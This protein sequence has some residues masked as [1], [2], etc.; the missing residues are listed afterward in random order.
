VLPPKLLRFCA[1]VQLGR[2]TAL[3]ERVFLGIKAVLDIASLG[4]IEDEARAWF[5]YQ[6]TG[7]ECDFHLGIVKID[8]EVVWG[9]GSLALLKDSRIDSPRTS[10]EKYG[11]IDE[12][13][14]QV[15][16]QS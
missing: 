4:S 7:L 9:D 1:P 8:F 2:Q 14:T 3:L 6:R 12:V 15:E 5:T 10:E 13:R 11:L 16:E